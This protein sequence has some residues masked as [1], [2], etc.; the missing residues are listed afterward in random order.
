M[1]TITAYDSSGNGGAQSQIVTFAPDDLTPPSIELD[2]P[3]INPTWATSASM[4]NISGTAGDDLA[5]AQITW[6]N[7]R[8]GSGSACGANTWFVNGIPLKAGINS[9]TVIAVDAAG[10]SATDVLTVMYATTL[11]TWQQTYFTP[12]E[13]DDPNISGDFADPD[14]DGLRN[15][16][17]YSSNSDPRTASATNTPIVT[18]DPSYLSLTYTKVLAAEDLTYTVEESIDLINWSPAASIDQ[19][20]LDDGVTQIIRANV[21]IDGADRLFLR[22][23]VSH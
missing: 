12:E 15:L 18:L 5:V 23:G 13:L 6:E 21:L 2:F 4:L 3:T 9:I 19:I 16:F 11:Q 22:L 20:L 7:D 17:E 14:R 8:G 1:I 10:N